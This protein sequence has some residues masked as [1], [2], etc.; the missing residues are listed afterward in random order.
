MMKMLFVLVAALS[1]SA[2]LTPGAG[3]AAVYVRNG[4]TYPYRAHGHYYRYHH[5]GRYYNY[6]H[7]YRTGV[8]VYR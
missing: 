4:I 2:A 5:H 6:R 3:E 1:L 8:C 7:C